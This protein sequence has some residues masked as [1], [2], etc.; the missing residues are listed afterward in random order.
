PY[1]DNSKRRFRTNF[2]ES[3][4]AMLEDAFR[5]SHYPDQQTKRNMAAALCI[6]E[7]RVTVWFQ[8]RRAKWRRKE[9]REK[10]KKASSENES[11]RS[12]HLPL[13][14]IVPP[15]PI[16]PDLP[17]ISSIP[18][19]I[20]ISSQ[21]STSFHQIPSNPYLNEYFTTPQEHNPFLEF[22]M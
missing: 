6:P 9:T 19:S 18:S 4:S 22:S 11:A 20:P 21:F 5:S 2:T 14:S 3:Q 16:L 13:P 15:L 10:D 17:S 12:T 1:N 7:D 8:N